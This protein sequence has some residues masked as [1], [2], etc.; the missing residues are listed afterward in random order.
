M[1]LE[2]SSI[3]IEFL[4]ILL[5]RSLILSCQKIYLSSLFPFIMLVFLSFNFSKFYLWYIFQFPHKFYVCVCTYLSNLPLNPV[6]SHIFSVS[7]TSGNLTQSNNIPH[8]FCICVSNWAFS[9]LS[10]FVSTRE[11]SKYHQAWIFIARFSCGAAQILEYLRFLPANEK[12]AIVSSVHISPSSVIEWK[13]DFRGFL[14]RKISLT[15]IDMTW[16]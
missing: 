16:L 6:N 9:K 8:I 13:K 1:W 3:S 7:A 11:M 2:H 4:S 15:L 12:T 14:G 5:L 10:F